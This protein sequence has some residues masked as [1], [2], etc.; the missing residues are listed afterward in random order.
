MDIDE[1]ITLREATKML[2]INRSRVGVLCREGR[3]QGAKKTSLGWIIPREAV[4]NFKRLPPG[5]KPKSPKR[6][7]DEALIAGLLEE[8]PK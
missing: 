8:L 5:L 3:F 4:I 2:N 6:K 1:F 7:D